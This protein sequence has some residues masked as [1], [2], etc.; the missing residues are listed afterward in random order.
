MALLNN[1]AVHHRIHRIDVKDVIGLS[2]KCQFAH[3]IVLW[4]HF[5]AEAG[6]VFI[7]LRQCQLLGLLW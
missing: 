1:T 6:S 4:S 3:L 7:Y 5:P 2:S